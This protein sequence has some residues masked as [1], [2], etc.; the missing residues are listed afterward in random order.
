MVCS[1][2]QRQEDVLVKWYIHKPLTKP[3]KTTLF[4]FHYFWHLH[5]KTT[6]INYYY[7]FYCSNGGQSSTSSWYSYNNP[8]PTFRFANLQHQ[9]WVSMTTGFIR[10]LGQ[11]A[12]TLFIY[13]DNTAYEC[14]ELIRKSINKNHISIKSAT[15]CS[16]GQS[17]SRRHMSCS[18]TFIH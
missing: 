17:E 3:A 5:G 4:L 8:P 14:V 6:T 13:N 18:S 1:L 15:K 10:R 12:M 9:K 11:L 2:M 7:D 16:E